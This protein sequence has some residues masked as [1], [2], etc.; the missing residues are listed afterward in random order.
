MYTGKNKIIIELQKNARS[1]WPRFYCTLNCWETPEEL[2]HLKID[3]EYGDLRPIITEAM[4][5]IEEEVGKK[6]TSHYWNTIH[7]KDPNVMDEEEFEIWWENGGKREYTAKFST[8]R[9]LF[10]YE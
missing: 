6:A 8:L 1:E 10:N 9:D 7:R 4:E 5:Y 3:R 2:E